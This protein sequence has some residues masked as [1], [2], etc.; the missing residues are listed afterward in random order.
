MFKTISAALL[1]ASVLAAPAFAATTKTADAPVIKATQVKTTAPKASVLNAKMSKHYT[2]HARH[3]TKHA[4]HY[5]KAGGIKTHKVA[6]IKSHKKI[7]AIKTHSKVSLK[8]TGAHRDQTRLIRSARRG[9]FHIAP[10][11]RSGKA[12]P[13]ATL[14]PVAT[15][16]GAVFGLPVKCR[17]PFFAGKV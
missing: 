10:A 9:S 3:Y 12:G 11:A 7:G 14:S 6:A 17:F 1:A 4:R 13:L 5:A 16:A 8:H 2:K 15:R